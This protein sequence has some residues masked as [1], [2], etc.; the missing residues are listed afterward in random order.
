[1]APTLELVLAWHMHQPDY[2]D[3]ESGEFRLPWVYLH[4]LKDYTDMAAHLERHPGM[5]AVINLVPVLA[6]QIED[7]AEQI[8]TGRLR[9]PVLRLLARDEREPLSEQERAFALQSC[10]GANHD[11]RVA[12]FAAYRRLHEIALAHGDSASH[13]LSDQYFYDLVTWYHLGWTGETVRR[14]EPLVARLLH[15]AVGFSHEDRRELVALIGTLMSELVPRYARL[16]A[17]GRIELST[18][19]YFH[20]LAPLL[21]DFK[22]AHETRPQDAL[23]EAEIYPGGEARVTWHIDEAIAS[24]VRR[25]GQAPAGL[26]P[27]EGALSNALLTK[28]AAHDV[29]WTASGEGVLRNSRAAAGMQEADRATYLYTPYR[30]GEGRAPLVF[31]RDDRLSDLIGFEYAKWHSRD[32]AANFV[33]ELEAIATHAKGAVPLVSVILDGENCWEHY[34]YN[35]F[36]FLDALYAGLSS[37]AT[38]R[39]TTFGALAASSRA[40]A[41]LP[42]IRAGSWVYGDLSTWIGAAEKNRAWDLLCE[43]KRACDAAL[44]RLDIARQRAALRQLGACE[45]SD[46]F[47]WLGDYNEAAAVASFD[48]LY[49][50][51]LAQLYRIL[52]LAPPLALGRPLAQGEGSPEGGGAMRRAG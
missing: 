26:W 38:L 32:A 25:F 50:A 13:Y 2:R 6:D 3:C 9:D 42:N 4:A 11:K 20:P 36:Y 19:P 22:A 28:L 12:P 51:N 18:T 24:H 27:A 45:S 31:F 46:W 17:E 16:A 49:R 48:M 14:G 23:P 39:P 7:Y 33:S 43:A 40:T 10:L 41:R 15:Q 21:L 37:H 5:R 34:P 44:P 29:G 1:M 52:Q 8:A 47:W 30:I 35:G